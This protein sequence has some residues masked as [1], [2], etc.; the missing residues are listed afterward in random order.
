MGDASN[1]FR[2]DGLLRECVFRWELLLV[3]SGDV[4]IGM[5]LSRSNL[6]LYFLKHDILG[7]KSWPS[8]SLCI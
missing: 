8:T 1:A 7:A 4:S 5:E 6:K 3:E 2:N